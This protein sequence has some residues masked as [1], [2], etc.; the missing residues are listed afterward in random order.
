MRNILLVGDSVLRLIGYNR[1]VVA[2]KQVLS[3]KTIALL[4]VIAAGLLIFFWLRQNVSQPELDRWVQESGSVVYVLFFILYTLLSLSFMPVVWLNVLAG[5]YFGPIHGTWL[6]LTAVSLSASVSFVASRYFINRQWI[7]EHV[8]ERFESLK[9]MLDHPRSWLI[10]FMLRL[11]NLVPF[12][13]INYLAGIMN[14]RYGS[15]LVV[16]IIGSLPGTLIWSGLGA[17]IKKLLWSI[18]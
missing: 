7:L 9:H 13:V 3:L 14:I 4:I 15:Y 1:H 17:V 11:S 5:M 8:P 16:T 2:Q 6:I 10:V 12:A 18:F